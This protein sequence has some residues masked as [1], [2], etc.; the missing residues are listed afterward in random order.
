MADYTPDDEVQHLLDQ[1]GDLTPAQQEQM[2]NAFASFV[3]SWVRWRYLPRAKQFIKDR[4]LSNGN[5]VT[6]S[7]AG[8]TLDLK[9]TSVFDTLNFV[10]GTVAIN[11]SN[12]RQVDI[13]M[14]GGADCMFDYLVSS[15]FTTLAGFTE[16]RAFTSLSGCTFYG[17]STVAGAAAAISA[18]ANQ[19]ATVLFICSGDYVENVN[20]TG[21]ATGGKI[22]IF[23]AG[24][25]STRLTGATS[26]GTALNIGSISQVTMQ[27]IKVGSN[28]SASAVGLSCGGNTDTYI[29]NCEFVAN[30]ASA[31]GVVASA[32][33]RGVRFATCDFTGTGTGIS[34]AG[35]YLVNCDIAATTGLTCTASGPV[36]AVGCLF[37]GTTGVKAATSGQ[38]LRT[39]ITDSVFSGCTTGISC[40]AGPSFAQGEFIGNTFLNCATAIHFG[41]T[42]NNANSMRIIGNHFTSGNAAHKAI[43]DTSGALSRSVI[44]G[45][46]FWV[47]NSGNEL[48]GLDTT[49]NEIAHN[50]TSSGA[51]L[52]DTHTPVGSGSA[53]SSAE[54]F[55]TIGNSST[56]SAERA[57]TAGNNITVTDGGANSTVTI[58]ARQDHLF[59]GVV[60]GSTASTTVPFAVVGPFPRAATIVNVYAKC[61]ENVTIGATSWIG[62]VHKILAAN[63]DS[64]GQGTTIYTTQANRPTIANTHMA[65]TAT[66]PDVTA[67]AAGDWLAFYTDQAGTNAT[68]VTM[69]VSVT[70][71]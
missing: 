57:L 61:A 14:G 58:A 24:R 12:A 50:V 51:T 62:D 13:T 1:L 21:P 7:S 34:G 17:Y 30:H 8:T 70:Y 9:N 41:T 25:H 39:S 66:A 27:N 63:Q 6:T 49:D 22:A 4:I 32:G 28:A 60:D 71:P 19:S 64:D 26:G 67:V 43:D 2:T 31:T 11:S 15:C 36:G 5:P 42:A 23:G 69:A 3:E 54:A 35:I 10:G 18:L 55:V 16:G 56:L 44:I 68:F 46:T 45:N 53:A 29:A 52:P 40:T 59:N 37:T 47:L 38:T 48:I 20:F 65:T 33:T